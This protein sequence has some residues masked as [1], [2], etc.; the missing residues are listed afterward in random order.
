MNGRRQSLE[1]L[2]R[3]EYEKMMETIAE[4]ETEKKC[5]INS[6]FPSSKGYHVNVDY[7][8]VLTLTAGLEGYHVNVDGQHVTSFPYRTGFVLEDATGLSLNG[9][10]DVQSVFAGTLP[11]THPSFSPQKHLEL[12]PS[13]QAHPLP[14]EPV[15]IF[16]GILSA[17]NHFAERMSAA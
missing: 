16:I 6:V 2:Q 15:E 7:L 12:L 4:W 8:F 14:D 5:T 3:S 13:W 11:T 17:G 9:D 1:E 10:L